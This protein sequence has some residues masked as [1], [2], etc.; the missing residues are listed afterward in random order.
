MKSS[1]FQKN[2]FEG[3]ECVDWSKYPTASTKG[4]E[5]WLKIPWPNI[6]KPT[7]FHA[8]KARVIFNICQIQSYMYDASAG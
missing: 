7:F 1:F 5:G 3:W 8:F 2:Y 6:L 4:L